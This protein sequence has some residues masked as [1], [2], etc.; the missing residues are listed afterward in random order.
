MCAYTHT[1]THTRE[2]SMWKDYVSGCQWVNDTTYWANSHSG[3]CADMKKRQHRRKSNQQSIGC[4]GEAAVEHFL[5]HV[6]RPLILLRGQNGIIFIM[7]TF[8]LQFA[9]FAHLQVGKRNSRNTKCFSTQMST[10]YL[11]SPQMPEMVN[12]RKGV[13]ES[14]RERVRRGREGGDKGGRDLKETKTAEGRAT[15]ICPLCFY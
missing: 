11:W 13:V 7:S 6:W 8:S 5:V 3:S 4:V 1:H 10:S 9:V 12:G 14:R 2:S 15:H